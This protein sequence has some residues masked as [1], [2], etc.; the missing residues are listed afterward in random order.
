MQGKINK[1][2]INQSKL[3]IFIYFP[4]SPHRL[5]HNGQD[6]T[7]PSLVRQNQKLPSSD[8]KLFILADLTLCSCQSKESAAVAAT[9]I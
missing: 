8:E 5:S 4:V 7:N 2:G 6:N 1:K 3:K 9:G